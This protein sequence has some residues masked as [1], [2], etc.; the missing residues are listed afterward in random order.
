MT[1]SEPRIARQRLFQVFF[2][3]VFALVAWQLNRILSG[4]YVALL[5]AVLLALITHPVHERLT[6]LFGGRASAAAALTTVLVVLTVV[7]PALGA[8]YA[9]LR[10]TGKLVPVVSTWLEERGL[11]EAEAL[12]PRLRLLW[13]K[14]L[15]LAGRA[16][17]DPRETMVSAVGDLA[18]SIRSLAGAV[19]KNTLLFLFQLV[20]M[21]VTLFFLLRDGARAFRRGLELVPLPEQHKRA[22]FDRMRDTL[23][24]VMRGVFLVSALE[25]LACALGFWLFGVP[26]ATLLGLLAAFLAPIPVV[27]CASVW[28]PVSAGLALSGAGSAGVG[29]LVWCGL[30]MLLAENFLRPLLIGAEA[31]LPF[32]LLFFGML[33]GLSAYGIAGIVV[34]PVVV[35]LF[36]A[37]AEIYRQEYR[38]LLAARE[39][40]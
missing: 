19:L 28:L 4:F 35:A 32:L 27:G 2:F 24:A 21:V 8:G 23:I 12:P 11:P 22:L 7:L 33:G 36:L 26:F 9:A 13:E 17:V 6:R 16:P 14:A 37:I 25:G 15:P 20:V 10:Q 31:R 29:V 30:V 34:G 39:D 3:T 38:W 18:V 1:A 5:G 40:A